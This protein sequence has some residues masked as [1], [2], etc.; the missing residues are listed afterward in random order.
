MAR[1]YGYFT[2]PASPPSSGAPRLR[3]PH[4][5]LLTYRST[6]TPTPRVERRHSLRQEAEREDGSAAVTEVR[7]WARTHGHTVPDRGR[8]CADIWDLARR[9]SSLTSQRLMSNG[10]VQLS[11]D[12]SAHNRSSTRAT[13]SDPPDLQRRPTRSQNR[14][15]AFPGPTTTSP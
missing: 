2:S 8:L 13:L 7:A 3:H 5:V 9:P 4:R 11:G 1:W 12:P 14:R 15:G 10:T 6:T